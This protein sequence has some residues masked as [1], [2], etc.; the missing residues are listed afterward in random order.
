MT[1]TDPIIRVVLADDHALV[2]EGLRH[3]LHDEPG[4]LVVGEAASAPDAIALT[5]LHHPD[6]VLLDISMPGGG[7][8]EATR[9]LRAA[10]PAL[11]ILLLSMYDSMEYV[12][13]GVRLGAD[14]YLL[15]DSAGAE[16]RDAVRAVHAGGRYFSPS[17]TGALVGAPVEDGPPAP[18]PLAVLTA[19]ERD[20][21]SGVAR[22]LTNKAIAAEL[23]IGRRTVEAH[24]E[25]LMRKLD[26]RTVAGLTRLAI[27]Q[28]LVEGDG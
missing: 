11:R 26:I 24:R 14:G 17:L 16:L 23:G 19:R 28:G 2:R 1:E 18:D 25:N 12:R 4:F 7:G 15:K 10:D 20:V 9:V 3:V 27:A 5:T 6:V 22:G 21:L 13:E 8:L